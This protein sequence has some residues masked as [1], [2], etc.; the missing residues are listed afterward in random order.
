MLGDLFNMHMFSITPQCVT[1]REGVD[2]DLSTQYKI[3]LCLKNT[4]PDIELS[5]CS[6]I[7]HTAP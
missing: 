7:V 6:F 1:R 2:K 4:V 5:A 3:T